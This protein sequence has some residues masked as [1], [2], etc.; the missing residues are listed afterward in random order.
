[1]VYIYIYI[2]IYISNWIIEYLHIHSYKIIYS[3]TA[4]VNLMLI[5]IEL[6]DDHLL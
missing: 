6:S 2:Y 5:C 3:C 4:N 1:M